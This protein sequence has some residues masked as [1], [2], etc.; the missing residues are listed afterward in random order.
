MIRHKILGS[1]LDKSV[2]ISLLL[3]SGEKD[4]K[5]LLLGHTSDMVPAFGSTKMFQ[6]WIIERQIPARLYARK[7]SGIYIPLCM[8]TQVK[9]I[10][11]VWE[12]RCFTK[13]WVQISRAVEKHWHVL[14]F[15]AFNISINLVWLVRILNFNK[16]IT[17]FTVI[18]ISSKECI[19]RK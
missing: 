1:F 7:K 6:I 15:W 3:S 14:W 5:D 2:T 4:F 10:T 17:F 16:I 12:G 19:W 18:L 9:V 11:L 13:Y 8:R